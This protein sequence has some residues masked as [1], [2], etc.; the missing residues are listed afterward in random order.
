MF[1]E[2]LITTTLVTLKRAPLVNTNTSTSLLPSWNASASFV[3]SPTSSSGSLSRNITAAQASLLGG[4]TPASA[5]ATSHLAWDLTISPPDW[6]ASLLVSD[7]AISPLALDL[8]VNIVPE[9]FP[10]VVPKLIADINLEL[11]VLRPKREASPKRTARPD[12]LYPLAE[13]HDQASSL[14]ELDISLMVWRLGGSTCA[15]SGSDDMYGAV[16][17]VPSRLWNFGTDLQPW[18]V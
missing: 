14:T 8:H 16:S 15:A 9:L 11:L 1:V 18:E 17:A 12:D 3:F 4:I 5:S 6:A 10:A 2:V 7:S 13:F